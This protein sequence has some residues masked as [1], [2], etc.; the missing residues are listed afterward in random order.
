MYNYNMK[1][2]IGNRIKTARED[3]GLL[4][5]DLA[6][7]VGFESPTAISL[8]E[9]GERKVSAEMLSKIADALHVDVNFL[10]GKE[11]K[12]ADFMYALR[13]DKNIGKEDKK[14]LE[15]FYQ[16]FKDRKK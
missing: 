5:S 11:T 16:L 10:L 1:N 4:Q 12:E 15:D 3:A 13:A 7:T 8:I 6:R 14:K 2:T 9:G